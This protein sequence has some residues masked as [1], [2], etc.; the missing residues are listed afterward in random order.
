MAIPTKAKTRR[1]R[2]REPAWAALPTD[3]LLDKRICDLGLR[4]AGSELEPCIAQLYI[5]L[6]RKGIR[7]RPHC[8]LSDE[9]YS[10]DG[11]PGIAIPFYMAHPRLKRLEREQMIEVEGGSRES[12]MKFLRHETAHALSH[13]YL[14][15]RRAGW[16]K[17]FGSPALPY[18]ETYLPK[19]YSRRYVVHLEG[20][21]AQSHP[22]EDWAETFAVWLRPHSDWRARYRGWSAL[23]K[24]EYVDELMAEIRDKPARIRSR[25]HIDPAS[26]MRMTL[27]EYYDDKHAR[28]MPNYPAIF[29]RHLTRLF[30]ND[31]ADRQHE[32]ASDYLKRQRMH[33]LETVSRWTFEYQYRIDQVLKDIIQRCDKLH[34]HVAQDNQHLKLEVVSC[35]TML[36][37]NHLHDEGF[38][39]AL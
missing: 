33:L 29:D 19:P 10:P 6:E 32:K 20:W 24:L 28:Y 3:A 7:F 16:R 9:W 38:H 25:R 4:I 23:K 18:P 14:V 12:C 39:V 15:H 11:V 8:W 2:A 31:E 37:M 21:Y 13:A 1:R 22:H 34:L 26:G 27:R 30:S 5:E 35:L 36:V 17:H